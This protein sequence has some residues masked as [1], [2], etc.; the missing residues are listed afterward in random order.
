MAA[1]ENGVGLIDQPGEEASSF[2]II[3]CEQAFLRVVMPFSRWEQNVV[4]R[5]ESKR[6]ACCKDA[7]HEDG[8]G[9]ERSRA[10]R[11]KSGATTAEAFQT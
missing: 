7:I 10:R 6:G 1:E 5:N 8:K 11:S 4:L 3:G 9:S 2:S